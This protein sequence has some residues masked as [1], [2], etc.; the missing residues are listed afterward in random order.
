MATDL[1]ERFNFAEEEERILALWTR[2]DAFKTSL[3]LSK[4]KPEV[5]AACSAGAVGCRY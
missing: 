2:L 5:G 4:D 3:E 1:P